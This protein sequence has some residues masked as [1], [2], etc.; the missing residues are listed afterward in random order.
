M[1]PLLEPELPPLELA[2]L[3]LDEPLLPPVSAL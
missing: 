1:P 2:P 3:P